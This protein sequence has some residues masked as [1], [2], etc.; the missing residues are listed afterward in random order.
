MNTTP[1]TYGRARSASKSSAT[2][3]S[4]P[5]C[6]VASSS[7]RATMSG[8]MVYATM[9]RR[10]PPPPIVVPIQRSGVE[11]MLSVSHYRPR[12]S[13]LKAPRRPLPPL[14]SHLPPLPTT[15]QPAVAMSASFSTTI[16]T[17]TT[18]LP[19]LEEDTSPRITAPLNIPRSSAMQNL[20]VGDT[21]ATPPQPGT[22]LERYRARA[23]AKTLTSIRDD[24]STTAATAELIETIAAIREAA[25]WDW[26]MPP[27]RRPVVRP[28]VPQ[29]KPLATPQCLPLD[30]L[31]NL[32]N[33]DDFTTSYLPYRSDTPSDDIHPFATATKCTGQRTSQYSQFHSSA[34]SSDIGPLTPDDVENP[35]DGSILCEREFYQKDR[36]R[37]RYGIPF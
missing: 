31:D 36:A 7:S 20:S 19:A 1:A 29:A 28:P 35:F 5:L 11:S 24:T 27:P 32:D 8:P 23:R 22:A 26:P 37:S 9:P 33:L 17:Q 30:I 25:F 34:P 21:K 16:F 18:P 2:E 14:P 13:S 15:L 12:T 4:S 6:A 10:A 3:T